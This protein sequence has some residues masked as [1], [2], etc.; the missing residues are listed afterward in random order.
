MNHCNLLG[1]LSLSTN[2]IRVYELEKLC[3]KTSIF[4]K[5]FYK[6]K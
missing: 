3:L 5:E 2:I 4:P 6:T 1:K